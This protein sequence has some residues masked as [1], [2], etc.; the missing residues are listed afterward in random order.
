MERGGVGAAAAGAREFH[1]EMRVTFLSGG[2]GTPKLLDSAPELL[3]D[4]SVVVNT[5]DDVY[6]GGNLVC[7][8]VDTVLYTLAG[9]IDRRGWWGVEGDTTA[10][11]EVLREYGGV[12][13]R[14]VD[15]G[16]PLG[17]H[18]SFVGAENFMTIGDRDRALHVARTELLDAGV[19]LTE[20]TRSLS[21][22]LGVEAGVLPVSDDAVATWIETPESEM[23]FQEWLLR[24]HGEPEVQ[25]VEFRGVEE[26]VG[27]EEVMSALEQPVV[28]GPSNPV[29][30]IG[31]MLELGGVLE[32]LRD[33]RV[34]AVSPFVGGEV[35]SGPAA[36]LMPAVGLSPD[37]LGVYEAYNSFLD[38]LVVDEDALEGLDGEVGCEVLRTDTLIE[39]RSDSRRLLEEVV[40]VV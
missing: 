38:V 21:D 17:Q 9:M 26:A 32:K 3:D 24:R 22:K 36:D 16:R 19:G 37:S 23:H 18:R 8:D 13:P 28:I 15:A 35:V 31:P 7:P 5:A 10:T 30:S 4:F 6:V 29:T 20:A 39:T 11:H 27:T 40:D 34:A 33:T 1:V 2:T 25:G 12:E 14:T